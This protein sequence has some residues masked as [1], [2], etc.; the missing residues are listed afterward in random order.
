MLV[1]VSFVSNLFTKYSSKVAVNLSVRRLGNFTL[2]N[3][4]FFYHENFQ[5]MHCKIKLLK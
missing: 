2:L 3:E 1:C 4:V 5:S